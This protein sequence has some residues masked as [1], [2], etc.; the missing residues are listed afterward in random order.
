[1][2]KAITLFL[3]ACMCLAF[4]LCA[5]SGI[6]EAANE[7]RQVATAWLDQ[8][9]NEIRIGGY[10]NYPWNYVLRYFGGEKDPDPVDDRDHDRDRDEDHDQDP[11][12]EDLLFLIHIF[13][14]NKSPFDQVQCKR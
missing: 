6:A 9:G 5:V 7:G 10:Y 1:M 4:S 3:A 13:F 14:L 11:H 12:D 2:K 8:T